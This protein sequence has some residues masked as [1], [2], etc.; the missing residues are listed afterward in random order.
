MY[1][2]IDG[3]LGDYIRINSGAMR[4]LSVNSPSSD[5]VIELLVSLND[6]KV[7]LLDPTTKVL[8]FSMIQGAKM[9]LKQSDRVRQQIEKSEYLN[10]EIFINLLENRASFIK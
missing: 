8:V 3:L 9:G 6:C 2:A 10:N 7:P 4:R 5:D 1:A